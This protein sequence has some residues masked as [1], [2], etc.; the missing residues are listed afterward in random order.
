VPSTIAQRRALSDTMRTEHFSTRILDARGHIDAHTVK[1]QLNLFGALHIINTGLASTADLLPAMPALGFGPT[2]QFSLGGRTSEDW[3]KKWVTPGLRRMDHYPPPLYLLP[4]NEVQYQHCG[5]ARVLFFCHTPPTDG[6]RTFLHAARHVEEHLRRAGPLGQK[7]L[8]RLEQHGLMIETGFLDAR[9]P[10]KAA[11]YFQSWQERFSTTDPDAAI[12]AAHALRHQHDRCWWR[13]EDGGCRTLM[14]RITLS[15]FKTDR[16]GRRCLRFPRLA[17]GPPA[18]E[19]GYRR[20]PLGDGAELTDDERA[21]LMAAYLDTRQGIRWQKGDLIVF[22]NVRFGHSRES[23]SGPREVYVGMA[24]EIWDDAVAAPQPPRA[25]HIPPLRALRGAGRE[26]YT[27]PGRKELWAEQRSV[28]IF[29]ARGTLDDDTLAAIRR[30]LVRHGSVHVRDTGLRCE[31]AAGL[32]D[33]VLEKLG[34]GPGEQFRWGGFTSG[35]TA[36]RELNKTL[37]ATDDYPSDRWLLPHNEILYQRQ[38]PRWLLFFSARTLDPVGGGRTFAHDAA[39]LEDCIR[40]CGAAGVALLDVLREEGLLIEMGFLDARHPDKAT[41]Y[42][43]SW[44]DRF[45]TDDRGLALTRCQ[46]ATD[47]F[48]HCWWLEEPTDG[49]PTYTLMT[50]IRVPAFQRDPDTGESYLFFPRIALDGPAVNNG[51]RRFP[52]GSGT[53]F[54]PEEVDILLDAFLATREGISWQEG[55]LLLLDNIRCGHSR[56]PFVGHRELGVAMSG[57]FWTDDAR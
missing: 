57:R 11:N 12:A 35:R 34:F 26:H 47:Q 15:A 30:E 17:L 20:Y 37:R 22:D 16:S 50:R 7:L 10:R 45:D 40:A 39:R 6:G 44:Q 24:G 43:R 55:H 46:E 38:M 32:P 8:Q 54:S 29:D 36:R 4:N 33:S 2:E 14:T 28:R 18:L 52:R 5:P 42:F 21:L 56:E 25:P 53:P 9:H 23:F 31:T 41:N 49:A 51:H 1:T 27:L 13:E 19:N 3:Q 48:D